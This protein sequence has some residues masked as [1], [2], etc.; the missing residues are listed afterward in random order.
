[1]DDC[2]PSE[3]TCS[4]VSVIP[5]QTPLWTVHDKVSVHQ[6]L[7]KRS[8]VTGKP[9]LIRLGKGCRTIRELRL[10]ALSFR[11]RCAAILRLLIASRILRYHPTD[12][13]KLT[14]MT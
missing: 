12:R 9:Y 3:R 2:L 5:P 7:R 11:C 14:A 13:F 6:W 1:M 4:L 8:R 10:T